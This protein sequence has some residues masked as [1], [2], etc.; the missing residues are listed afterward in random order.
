MTAYTSDSKE[1]RR[2]THTVLKH[3]LEKLRDPARWTQGEYARNADG[4]GL[5]N[6]KSSAAVCFCSMGAILSAPEAGIAVEY[7]LGRVFHVFYKAYE[8]V[9]TVLGGGG[10]NISKWNDAPERTHAEVVAMF[11]KAI[12]MT[13]SLTPAAAE[14]EVARDADADEPCEGSDAETE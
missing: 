6:P 9:Q 13:A 7:P 1:A 4:K 3:A 5:K 11:E 10:V 2:L 12:E 8:V 14:Q